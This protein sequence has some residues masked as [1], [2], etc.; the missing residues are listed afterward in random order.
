MAEATSSRHGKVA[1][2][3]GLTRREPGA[4]RARGGERAEDLFSK[5]LAILT[6]HTL[7]PSGVLA[8]WA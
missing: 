5:T 3:W 1:A 8:F 4:G 6:C 7:G 2:E